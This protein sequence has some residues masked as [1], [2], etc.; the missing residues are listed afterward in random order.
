MADGGQRLG[1]QNEGAVLAEGAAEIAAAE[2]ND[3]CDVAWKIQQGQF[4]KSKNVH[5]NLHS[6]VF[7][8]AVQTVM[9]YL[10]KI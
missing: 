1:S 4:L 2:E 10:V 9:K 6:A 8:L 7:W 5:K 3:G